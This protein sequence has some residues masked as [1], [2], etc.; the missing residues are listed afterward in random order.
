MFFNGS[1]PVIDR[2]TGGSLAGMIGATQRLIDLVN[3][4]T[5]IIPGHGPMATVADL[6]R[7][8]AMLEDVRDKLAPFTARRA[9]I[10]EVLAARPLADLDD[11]WGRGFLR[12]DIFTRMAYPRP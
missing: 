7:T 10:D 11:T 1:F 4:D 3:P 8:L 9:T 12:S 6:R 2:G 5:R